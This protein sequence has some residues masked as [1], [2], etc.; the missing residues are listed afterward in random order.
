VAASRS[1]NPAKKAAAR[2]KKTAASP[3]GSSAVA[4]FKNISGGAVDLPSG[5][6]IKMR[7]PGMDT[8]VKSGIIPNSLLPIIQ[9]AMKTGKTPDRETLTQ[10][11][12]SMDEMFEMI[13]KV[14][15]HCMVDPTCEMPPDDEDERRTDQLYADEVPIEDKLF[16]YQLAVGG[17]RDV[18][19]FRKEL[20][21][22][23]AP[24]PREQATIRKAQRAPRPRKAR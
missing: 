11:V 4:A 7:M 20:D 8:F 3:T 22:D 17:T 9:D 15:C 16:I 10:S 19:S 18:E 5:I 21:Q 23:L 13:D 24:T 6:T 12:D 1:G 14:T 2:P